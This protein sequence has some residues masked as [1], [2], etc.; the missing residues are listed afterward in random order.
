M[1]RYYLGIAVRP[2]EHIAFL[3]FVVPR[4]PAG[5]IWAE[6]P[7]GRWFKFWDAQL[8]QTPWGE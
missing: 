3:P 2:Q 6:W 8:K 4:T 7:D 1:T 5:W